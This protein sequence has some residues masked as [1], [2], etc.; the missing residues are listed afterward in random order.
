MEYR[1]IDDVTLSNFRRFMQS[2]IPLKE[3]GSQGAFDSAIS[4]GRARD[5][6]GGQPSAIA[7][8]I[9]LRDRMSSEGF[10][11]LCDQLCDEDG[12]ED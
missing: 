8:M 6:E 9:A 5:E 3:F 11:A 4:K 7:G 2:G 12:A 10:R 1:M